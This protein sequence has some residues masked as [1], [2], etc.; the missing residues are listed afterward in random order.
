MSD[1][2]DIKHHVVLFNI[3]NTYRPGMSEEE[4]YEM[5]RGFW[6]IRNAEL[7]QG[8]QYAFGVSDWTVKGVFPLDEWHGVAEAQIEEFPNRISDA[9]RTDP[10]RLFFTSNGKTPDEVRDMY[11]GKSVGKYMGGRDPVVPVFPR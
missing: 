3:R 5:T 1:S 4:V 8:A 9:H 2:V 11:L 6:I 10:R 7:I